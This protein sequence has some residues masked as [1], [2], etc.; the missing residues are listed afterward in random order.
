MTPFRMWVQNIYIQNCE[1]H[2]I[3]NEDRYTM[4]QYWTKYKWW[5][6]REYCYQKEK[7]D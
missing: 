4:Q 5:L 2:L 3:Y 6:K 1:E 7:N